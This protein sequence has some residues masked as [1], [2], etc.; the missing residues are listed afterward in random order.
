M[1]ADGKIDQEKAKRAAS[2]LAA[3]KMKE[4]GAGEFLDA[5][6]NISKE[7]AE[8]AAKK[9]VQSSSCF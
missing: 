1:G 9:K 7:A 3:D 2:K 5:E 8:A 6:G 4:M